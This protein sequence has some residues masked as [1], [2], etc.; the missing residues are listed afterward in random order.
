MNSPLRIKGGIVKFG[1]G[2]GRIS[3][4]GTIRTSKLDFEN[5]YYVDE[6]QHFNL[7]SVS[8]ICDKKNK[9]LFNRS[10][11]TICIVK[12]LVFHQRT[13]H[14]EIHHQF[15]R[16]A[17]EKNLIQV[18]KIHT[19]DNLTDLLTKAFNGPRFEYLVVHIGMVDM[20]FFIL[21]AGCFVFA[22][23]TIILLVVILPSGCFVSAG[24]TMILLVDILPAGCF[25]SAGSTTI[26]LVV[27]L[28]AGCFVSA[29]STMIL[30]YH[31]SAGCFISAGSNLF[32]LSQLG[33]CL[34]LLVGWSLPLVTSFLL[35][36]SNHADVTMY[37]LNNGICCHE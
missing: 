2:D 19:D 16:D 25:V 3:R 31:V 6:L 8:Q 22:G 37:L 15:I 1:G 34:I 7:F 4:K 10:R 12:N 28:P 23:S 26:L 9:V 20:A 30:L 32:L 5:V 35:V 17:N 21:P 36:V 33:F 27:I 13:K 24:S 18:L 14:I 29:G 11:S